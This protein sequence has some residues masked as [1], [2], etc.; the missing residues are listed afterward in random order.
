MAATSDD[1]KDEATKPFSLPPEMIRKSALMKELNMTSGQDANS[2]AQAEA[3]E[4]KDG[5][6][7]Q[8]PQI[9]PTD[10]LSDG[11]LEDISGGAWPYYTNTA[12]SGTAR[13]G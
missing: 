13:G 9:S 12:A 2:T 6:Q 4:S 7:N 1:A 3:L 8:T 5:A 11:S 10:A